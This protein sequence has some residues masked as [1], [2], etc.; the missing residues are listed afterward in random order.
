MNVAEMKTI[1]EGIEIAYDES[2]NLWR[3]EL[4]GRQRSADSLAKAKEYID[5]PIPEGKKAFQRIPAIRLRNYDSDPD[6][7]EITSIA[8]GYKYSNSKEVWFIGADKNRRKHYASDFIAVNDANTAMLA[9]LANYRA[10]VNRLN[11]KSIELYGQLEKIDLES[12][13]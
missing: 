10:E 12:Y 13:E 3:F 7:G 4:R 1:Y 5:K 6:R 9:T 11:Q 8:E 2:A